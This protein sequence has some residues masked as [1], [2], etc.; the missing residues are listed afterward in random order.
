VQEK[1]ALASKARVYCG[2]DSIPWKEFAVAVELFVGVETT[3][4]CL[5]EVMRDD[6]RFRH[7]SGWFEHVSE[8]SA[9]LLVQATGKVFRDPGTPLDDY[10]QRRTW[11]GTKKMVKENISSR[12]T[13]TKKPSQS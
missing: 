6:K 8:L 5:S 7:V 11:S 4:H 10:Q 3:T 2:P 13:R 1:I 9:S 12:S